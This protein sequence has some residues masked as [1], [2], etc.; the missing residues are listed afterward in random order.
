MSSII[1]FDVSIMIL[2]IMITA[3]NFFQRPT[4]KFLYYISAITSLTIIV[5]TIVDIYQKTSPDASYDIDSASF[6]IIIA[7]ILNIFTFIPR[8]DT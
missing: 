5:T 2:S 4:G 1:L 8:K 7:L 6:I 3:L